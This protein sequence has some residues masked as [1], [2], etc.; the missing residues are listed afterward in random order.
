MQYK[1]ATEICVS[2]QCPDYPICWR[3]RSTP[4]RDD[5]PGDDFYLAKVERCV[6]GLLDARRMVRDPR[7]DS[8]IWKSVNAHH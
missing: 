2:R 4:E 5:R 6:L 7:L 1:Q 8:H 3:A